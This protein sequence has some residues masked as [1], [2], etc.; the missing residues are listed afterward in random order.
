[1]MPRLAIFELLDVLLLQC[2]A[3]EIRELRRIAEFLDGEIVGNLAKGV[4]VRCEFEITLRC[5]VHVH[6][7]EHIHFIW[8]RRI[9]YLGDSFSAS[10]TV[11][12][13]VVQP[14]I[15]S[16]EL[17]RFGVLHARSKGVRRQDS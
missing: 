10:N 3:L 15:L 16:K 4:D 14:D 11:D 8:R 2:E 6:G 9:Q 12:L 5:G 13:P 17:E 1:T 7:T